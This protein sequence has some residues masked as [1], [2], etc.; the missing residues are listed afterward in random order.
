MGVAEDFLVGPA[1]GG[2]V[3]DQ[4]ANI[5]YSFGYGGDPRGTGYERTGMV[6]LD[7]NNGIENAKWEF[8][9]ILTGDLPNNVAK[10][11]INGAEPVDL[12]VDTTIGDYA[13]YITL[14]SDAYVYVD[15]FTQIGE[16]AD[17][18]PESKDEGDNGFDLTA[19]LLVGVPVLVVAAAAVLVLLKKKKAAKPADSA[20][21]TENPETP[22]EQ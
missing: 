7:L 15:D 12:K 5:L 22:D 10:V 20:E 21:T 4:H 9:A 11:S 14:H 17:V 19:I 8:A 6:K 13:T 3:Y 18:K 16:P 1:P 2:F